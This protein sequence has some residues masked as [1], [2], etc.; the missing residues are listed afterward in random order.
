M[1]NKEKRKLTV[2]EAVL[3]GIAITFVVAFVL[4]L[5]SPELPPWLVAIDPFEDLDLTQ[6]MPLNQSSF[7]VSV[8]VVLMCLGLLT[9]ILV[10]GA[11]L[12]YVVSYFVFVVEEILRSIY[13]LLAHLLPIN[14]IERPEF[15][16]YPN[17]IFDGV[18]IKRRKFAKVCV[19]FLFLL[20]MLAA[21]AGIMI[22]VVNYPFCR[23]MVYV[24]GIVSLFLILALL[25]KDSAD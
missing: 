13:N 9:S 23:L 15:F 14:Y 24:I 4:R 20:A 2:L 17:A 8:L 5:W 21:I 7:W 10:S 11:L 22:L 18:G 19:C 6:Y 1:K 16:E 3:L 25:L 12:C